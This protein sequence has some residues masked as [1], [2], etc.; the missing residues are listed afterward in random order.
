MVRYDFAKFSLVLS[1]PK[2]KYNTAVN[3]SR[4]RQVERSGAKRNEVETFFIDNLAHAV[5]TPC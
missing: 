3:T 5:H 4:P 2:R 1:L